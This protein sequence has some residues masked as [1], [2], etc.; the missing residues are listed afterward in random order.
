V[1]SSDAQDGARRVTTLPVC[2]V[3]GH[4]IGHSRS[5]LIHGFWLKQHGLAGSYQKRDVPPAE[6]ESF[7]QDIRSGVITGSNVTLPLKQ[8][9]IAYVDEL[10]PVAR[11]MGAA[12][13]LYCRNGRVIG[14]NTDAAGFI[15]HLD[16]SIPGW[17]SSVSSAFILGAGGA[18]R[19]VAYALAQRKLARVF[20]ANRDFNHAAALCDVSG[21]AFKPVEW[22][23][24]SEMVPQVDLIINTTP[25]GMTGQGDLEIDLDHMRVGTIVY[26]IVYAP[27]ETPL[28]A[29]ARRQG[30]QVVDGLGMLLHQAVRGFAYWFGVT[31]QV[32]PELRAVIV[33]DLVR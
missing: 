23:K 15:A 9:V 17:E 8:E 18:A 20:I 24:R 12:N 27:L 19:A 30:G 28:L 29:Q 10:T 5:P 11:L 13:T 1:S 14:D 26:D 32:T 31:P 21:P 16:V 25:L 3:I 22:A 4:P 2:Y 33:A 7:V 6:L